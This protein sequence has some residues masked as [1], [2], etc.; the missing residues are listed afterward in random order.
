MNTPKLDWQIQPEAPPPALSTIAMRGTRRR[1][2]GLAVNTYSIDAFGTD[3]VKLDYGLTKL[4]SLI[5]SNI[6]NVKSA[7]SMAAS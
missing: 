4:D 5:T 3:F 7:I 6:S 2:Q 1:H